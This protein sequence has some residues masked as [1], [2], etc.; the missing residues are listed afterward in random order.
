MLLP[1]GSRFFVAGR[2]TLG[3]LASWT[4]ATPGEHLL[5]FRRAKCANMTQW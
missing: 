2:P 5:F 1:P 4:N 3:S